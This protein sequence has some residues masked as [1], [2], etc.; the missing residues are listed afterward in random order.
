MET[1]Y[2][3]PEAKSFRGSVL[4]V[5]TSH[6]EWNADLLSLLACPACHGSL[7]VENS[8]LLCAECRRAYAIC[9]IPVLIAGRAEASAASGNNG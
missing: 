7:R 5:P 1:R 4:A 8:H 2:Q 9:G 3:G 6:I